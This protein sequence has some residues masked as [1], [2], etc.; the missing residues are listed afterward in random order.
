VEG[1]AEPAG[2]RLKSFSLI[3]PTLVF[4]I[5]LPVTADPN[6]IYVSLHEW[7][8]LLSPDY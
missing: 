6:D 4:I 2:L 1:Q 3:D 8:D 5:F 7:D